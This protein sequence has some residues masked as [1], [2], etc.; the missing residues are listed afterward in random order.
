MKKFTFRVSG[1]RVGDSTRPVES[2]EPI[3]LIKAPRFGLKVHRSSLAPKP[4]TPD[5]YATAEDYD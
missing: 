5:D 4:L 3:A 2:V 1:S